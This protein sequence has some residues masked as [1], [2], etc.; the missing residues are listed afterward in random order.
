MPQSF[1]QCGAICRAVGI[2][3]QT[4]RNAISQSKVGGS[5]RQCVRYFIGANVTH[6][7][8]T[9]VDVAIGKGSWLFSGRLAESAYIV[10]LRTFV[11][12]ILTT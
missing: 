9:S 1:V 5:V 11:C 12:L 3:L 6:C 4:V 10:A 7:D 2:N 8:T